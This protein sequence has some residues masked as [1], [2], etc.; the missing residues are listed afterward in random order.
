MKHTKLFFALCCSAALLAACDKN[1]KRVV[2]C[3]GTIAEPID[4]GLSVKWA[5]HNLG[6][7]K[8]QDFG[9]YFAW[10]ETKAKTSGFD[11]DNYKYGTNST[12][13]SKYD[14]IPITLKA[15]DVFETDNILDTRETDDGIVYY[16]ILRTTL[17]STDDAATAN[18]GKNWRMPTATELQELID[19]C[20][21]EKTE[22][23]F[24]ATSKVN[25]NSIFLPAA[26]Y[27]DGAEHITALK[28]SESMTT[29]YWSNKVD[30]KFPGDALR[31]NIKCENDT[32]IT[33][34][35]GST[36]RALGLSIRPV[37]K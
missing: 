27:I 15:D 12:E 6:A 24:T 7:E 4:L 35:V 36:R 18:W 37:Y 16:I 10:G 32:T 20:T 17:V 23:G 22:L 5:D 31:L 21:W 13:V 33:L 29:Y 25:G 1:E 2:D 11:W 30:E 19:N 34:K 8:P 28:M 14:T 9:R 3:G 26:G